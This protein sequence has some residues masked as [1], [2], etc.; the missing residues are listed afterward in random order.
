MFDI[1]KTFELLKRFS[2]EAQVG[3]RV[4]EMESTMALRPYIGTLYPR[5]KI[6][7][8]KIIPFHD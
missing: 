6:T 4:T 2:Q 7:P 5:T 8:P 3:Q 1:N